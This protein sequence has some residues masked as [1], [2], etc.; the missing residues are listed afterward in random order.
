MAANGF[1]SGSGVVSLTLAAGEQRILPDA[2]A[3]LRGTLPI[4]SDGRNVGGSLSVRA[5]PGTPAGALGAGARTYVPIPSGGSYGLFYP[6][7]TAAEC[8]ATTASVYGL[9]ENASQRSNLAVVNRGDAGD[10]ITLRVTYF[11]A[12]PGRPL[13]G[14]PVLKTLAP[15]EWFQFNRPL[16]DFGAAP[17]ATPR[18]RRSRAR[19]VSRRTLS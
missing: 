17:R 8:A 19:R 12:G 16:A 14:S 3:F 13:L 7:L 5:A 9:Q 4:E 11:G 1:G 2:I 15:G 18:S 6:G 10:A